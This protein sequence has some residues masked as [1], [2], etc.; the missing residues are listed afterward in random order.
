MLEVSKATRKNAGL[1][2]SAINAGVGLGTLILGLFKVGSEV[3]KA[4]AETDAINN[5][6]NKPKTEN[7]DTN[8]NV[9]TK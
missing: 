5:K 7:V 1:I 4:K 2:I 6:Y 3:R 8:V 9:D